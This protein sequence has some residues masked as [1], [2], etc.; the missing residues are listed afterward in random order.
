M[1]IQALLKRAQR[2][3]DLNNWQ[4]LHTPKNLVM[5]GGVEMAELMEIFQWL[6]PEESRYLTLE[7]RDQASEEI[8]DTFLHLL[9]LCTE[10]GIDPEQTIEQK[11][12]HNEKRFGCSL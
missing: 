8:T 11:M 1:N 6:S 3:R 12:R 2:I 10:L 4:S 7:Q 9:L 5:A